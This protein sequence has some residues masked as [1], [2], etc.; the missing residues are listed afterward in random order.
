MV[1]DKILPV[2][3]ES[4]TLIVNMDVRFRCVRVIGVLKEFGQNV[5]WALNLF[6]EL[7]PRSREL[8]IGFQLIPAC[9]GA[10]SDFFKIAGRRSHHRTFLYINVEALAQHA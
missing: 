5:A 6:E 1:A 4:E 8:R 9:P 2:V 3:T 7:M 10:N